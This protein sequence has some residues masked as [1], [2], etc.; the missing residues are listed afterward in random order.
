MKIN[1]NLIFS[2]FFALLFICVNLKILFENMGLDSTL[3][4]S[5]ILALFLV[6]S[7]LLYVLN[8]FIKLS[9][10]RKRKFFPSETDSK[11]IYHRGEDKIEIFERDMNKRKEIKEHLKNN[12]MRIPNEKLFDKKNIMKKLDNE[13]AKA[14]EEGLPLVVIMIDFKSFK[15]VDLSLKKHLEDDVLNKFADAIINDLRRTDYTGKTESDEIIIILP[16]TTLKKGEGVLSRIKNKINAVPLSNE[17][18]LTCFS[19]S[20]LGIHDKNVAFYNTNDILKSI[21]DL[22]HRGRIYEKTCIN[23]KL[24]TAKSLKEI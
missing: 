21:S 4:L 18:F 6:F 17:Y 10:K 9:K 12:L 13:I 1:K 7:A 22:M 3:Y 23:P 19:A 5:Y 15:D 8:F 14:K 2:V 16:N 11:Y 24:N 20:I